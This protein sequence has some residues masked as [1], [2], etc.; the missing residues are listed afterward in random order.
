M[1][2]QNAYRY[3]IQPSM[4]TNKMPYQSPATTYKS[5]ISN[6]PLKTAFAS[7][8]LWITL[9]IVIV[10]GL[11]ATTTVSI[12]VTILTLCGLTC[13]SHTS[14]NL[15]GTNGSIGIDVT[16][17]AVATA[18]ASALRTGT[19]YSGSSN[20]HSWQVGTCGTGIELTAT[21][22]TY[23]CNPGYIIRPCVGNSN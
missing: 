1:L 16:N 19:A 2:F 10:L 15:Y 8:V 18:I 23:S 12:V 14:L 5:N 20:G 17:T 6:V 4:T 11:V 7:K 3:P 21:G 22:A 9:S 13:S